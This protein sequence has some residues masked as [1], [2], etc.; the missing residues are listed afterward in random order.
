MLEHSA[1]FNNMDRLDEETIFE[2]DRIQHEL[3]KLR[4]EYINKEGGTYKKYLETMDKYYTYDTNQNYFD[5]L[6]NQKVVEF[7]DPITGQID[8]ESLAKW[9]A[10]N[11]VKK[12]KQKWHKDISD[13]WDQIFDIIG[14][15]NPK[16]EKLREDYNEI[17]SQYRN[18]GIVDSRFMSDEDI[19]A[20]DEIEELMSS[21]K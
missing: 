14:T 13:I 18:R 17:L 19:Q 9:K 10:Q 1:G 11:T 6:Y 2:I 3:N 20:I 7:T 16:I 21:Y 8:Q 5:R 15:Q 12:P 4:L